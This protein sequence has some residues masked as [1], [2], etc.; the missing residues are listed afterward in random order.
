MGVIKDGSSNVISRLVRTVTVVVFNKMN[1]NPKFVPAIVAPQ[2]GEETELII[3]LYKD[4]PWTLFPMQIKIEDTNKTL[5]P[6]EGTNLPVQVGPFKTGEE[7]TFYYVYTLNYSDYE[8]LNEDAKASGKAEVE[9]SIPMVTIL[10]ANA[11][12]ARIGNDYF[13][14]VPAAT[15][16]NDTDNIIT[17]NTA[18]IAATTLTYQFTVKSTGNWILTIGRE[19]GAAAPRASVSPSSGSYTTGTTVTVTVPENTALVE[20]KYILTLTN[21]DKTEDKTRT[22][23]LVHQGAAPKL[24]LSGT[25]SIKGNDLSSITVNVASNCDWEVDFDSG[26][27]N[28]AEFDTDTF[29]SG[30]GSVAIRMNAVNYGTNAAA[31]RPVTLRFTN[32]YNGITTDYTITQ[33]GLFTSNNISTSTLNAANILLDKTDTSNGC[34]I[35]L[36]S[37]AKPQ[38]HDMTLPSNDHYSVDSETFTASG[39]GTDFCSFKEIRLYTFYGATNLAHFQISSMPT[40]PDGIGS[41]SYQNDYSNWTMA[42]TV[43]SSNA[44]TSM[45]LKPTSSS[46]HVTGIQASYYY[47]Y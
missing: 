24:E 28:Y 18:T 6:S 10:D 25:N 9:V 29:G 7:S 42:S 37:S 30:N 44:V 16:Q 15:L 40:D 38:Y 22:A 26:S 46:W 13:S 12:T 34:T 31:G 39:S 41:V 36:H 23:E 35:N 21:T 43:S 17:P 33:R 47:W 20:R 14:G 5:N 3:P 27:E 32:K 2:K 45:T 8:A 1:V 19:H 4:L 11:T